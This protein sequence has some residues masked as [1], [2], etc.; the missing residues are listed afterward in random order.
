MALPMILAYQETE[1]EGSQDQGLLELQ[2]WVMG[3]LFI[4]AS[5]CLNLKTKAGIRDLSGGVLA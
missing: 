2:K 3:N 1:I 5:I 4:L